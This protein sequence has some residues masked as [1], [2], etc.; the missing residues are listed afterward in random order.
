MSVYKT[1]DS[2]GNREDLQ[3]TIWDVSPSDTPFMSSMAKQKVTATNHEWQQDE[4]RAAGSNAKVEGADAGTAS[5]TPTVRLGNYTQISDEVAQV[6]R[7]QQ[8]VDSAGRSNELD[9]QIVK[10]SMEL[11][12][13]MEH[14]LLANKAKN[15]W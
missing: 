9:Y 3:N 1:Y 4:L 13:D 7:T 12:L 5:H 10:K 8:D 15:C 11:K 14:E 6:S 2:V